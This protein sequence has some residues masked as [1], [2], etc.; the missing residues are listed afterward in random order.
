VTQYYRAP[1]ILM[2]ARHYTSAVD[3]WS[4]GCV[5]A[6]L[7]S[8]H[9][10]FQASGPM[11]Q[12]DLI[13]DVVGAPNV[14]DLSSASDAAKQHVLRRARRQADLNVLYSLSTDCDHE[15]VHLLCQLLVFNPERRIT[16]ANALFHPYLEDGRLRYH[17]CMCRCCQHVAGGRTVFTDD[18]EPC[19]P[20]PFDFHFEQELTTVARVRDKLYGL[21]CEIQ[22][23]NNMSLGLSTSSSAVYKL[24][25][26]SH[27]ILPT[28]MIQSPHIWD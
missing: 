24:A 18:A 2:G 16:A 6:E 15:V 28:E 25:Q 12:L 26:Q 14:D 23:R 9:I 13:V 17:S 1:E 27:Y 19:H 8:R 20:Q 21:C 10:L 5:L 3:M 22:H 4:V 7:L 11:Q